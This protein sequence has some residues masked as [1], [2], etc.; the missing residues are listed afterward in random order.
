MTDTILF[1]PYLLAALLSVAAGAVSFASPCVVPLVPGYLA[2]LAGLVGADAPAVTEEEVRTQAAERRAAVTG[3]VP[4][5]TRTPRLRR[6]R[7][8]GAAALFVLGFTV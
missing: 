6:F 8:A 7:V 3:E 5:L 4:V 1:G 2:Y